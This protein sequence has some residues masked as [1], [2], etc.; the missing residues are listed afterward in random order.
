MTRM[1]RFSPSNE[2]RR[3]QR[4]IDSVFQN[5]YPADGDREAPATGWTPRVD[6]SETE[7]A[8]HIHLDLPGVDKDDVDINLQDGTLTI[9][10]E[11]KEQAREEGTNTVRVERSFGQ[12]FRSFTLPQTIKQDDIRA[13]YDNGVLAVEVPKAEETKP[14]RIEI[15]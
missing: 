5:M 12:F 6:L 15:N 1:I 14:R 9:R 13:T 7:D 3:L 8:Y 11:R 4:E 2:L 10:G